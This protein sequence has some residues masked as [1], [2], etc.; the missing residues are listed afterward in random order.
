MNGGY[1]MID[2]TGLDLIKG[3]TPQTVNGMYNAVKR[4]MVINKPMYCLNAI[5]GTGKPV[6][7]IQFFAI[8][9]G[10]VIICTASTL[11]III[12]PQDSITINNLV[13]D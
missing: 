1:I 8:D 13:G 9:F 11:Q 10:D 5:W 3:E 2:A 12:T 7:P 4:A 6:T